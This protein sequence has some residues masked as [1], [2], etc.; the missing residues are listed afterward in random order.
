MEEKEWNKLTL[1]GKTADG[2]NLCAILSMLDPGLLIE[3]YSDLTGDSPYGEVLCGEMAEKD[4]TRFAVS[5]FL[6]AERPLI[7][8]TSF[9]RERL[10]D[11]G[12][13]ASV[14]VE[15]VREEDWAENWKKYYHPIRVGRVT[16][17]PAWQEYQASPGERILRMDP[18]TAF[19]TATHESTRM[20]MEFLDE[21][22]HGGERFL[23]I[24]CGSGI[25][26]L[27][28]SRLGAAFCAAYDLDPEAVR[29]TARNI[30]A[31]GAGNILCG[32]SDLLQSVDRSGG[33]YDF[34]AANI[35][36]DVLLRMAP[37]A[38]EVLRPGGLMAVSGVLSAR[39]EE[40]RNGICK[41][42]FT[43]IR[44]KREN[45]WVAM[46]FRRN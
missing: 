32:V 31:D 44:E 1:R 35:V 3:D 19:G 33:A 36:A 43:F 8:A 40:V 39:A 30:E 2:E 6:P 42:N 16:V 20:V 12:I 4:P 29:V 21:E 17:V 34:M 13:T 22:I 26:S 5:V 28:A 41:E 46:L 23:D 18:G 15:G 27:A 9:V 7:E 45:D 25:L 10:S 37:S 24:G 11:S 14:E 38:K